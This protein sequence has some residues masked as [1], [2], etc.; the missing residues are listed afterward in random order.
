MPANAWQ[1]IAWSPELNLFCAVGGSGGVATSPDGITWTARTASESNSWYGVAWS[2]ELNLFC[3]VSTSG[4]NRVMT[5]PDGITWTARS[6]AAANNWIS[7]TWSPELLLFCAAA[8]TGTNRLMTSPDGITWTARG[9]STNELTSVTWSPELGI[10]CAMALDNSNR[11]QT[12]AFPRKWTSSGR[13]T[14]ILTGAGNISGTPT[15]NIFQWHRNGK[16]VTVSGTLAVSVTTAN[17]GS[18][19][20]I[21]LPIP[22]TLIAATNVSGSAVVSQPTAT[23]SALVN[24]DVTNARARMVWAPSFTSSQTYSVHFTYYIP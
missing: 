20:A 11:C 14:P 24:G 19:L 12:S 17:S 6:A 9:S 10:F 21:R 13:Y 7:I 1:G 15:A 5:S 3:A 4:T 2:P 23:S 18:E 16:C 8:Q 22:S